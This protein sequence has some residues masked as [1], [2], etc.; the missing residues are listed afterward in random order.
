[1]NR[2]EFKTK[3]RVTF[4]SQEKQI[5][6]HWNC[7]VVIQMFEN[8]NEGCLLKRRYTFLQKTIF[9]CFSVRFFLFYL[10]CALFDTAVPG[11][12][13]CLLSVS[14]LLFNIP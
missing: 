14:Q 1:M 9:F 8:L 2:I 10:S 12:H 4:L 3:L 5:P 13:L 6:A 11:S 7:V